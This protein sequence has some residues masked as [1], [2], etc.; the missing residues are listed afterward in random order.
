MN[1]IDLLLA[2]AQVGL[3][4]L[5]MIGFLAILGILIFY[6]SQ[7]TPTTT[8]VLT[9]LLSVFGTILTMMM[10]YFFARQRPGTSDP[11][12]AAPVNNLTATI[13]PSK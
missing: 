5:A 13:G 11:T 2:R 4:F 8:T 9:G 3:A 1:Q 7:L 12:S 6:Q 10:N